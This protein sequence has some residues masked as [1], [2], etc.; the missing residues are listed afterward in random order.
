MFVYPTPIKKKNNVTVDKNKLNIILDNLVQ[1]T[2]SV[3][4]FKNSDT[5]PVNKYIEILGTG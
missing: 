3:V 2:I 4:P 5:T 1:L